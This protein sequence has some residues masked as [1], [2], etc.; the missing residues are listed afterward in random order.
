MLD[1]GI[2]APTLGIPMDEKRSVHACRRNS[3]GKK[4]M[5]A[6]GI[7]PGL[8]SFHLDVHIELLFNVFHCLLHRW[9][10]PQQFTSPESRCIL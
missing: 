5:F 10:A 8:S 2:L 9:L 7:P 3:Y 1:A 6:G 4:C